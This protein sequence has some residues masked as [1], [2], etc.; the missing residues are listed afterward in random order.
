MIQLFTGFV[1]SGKSYNATRIATMVADA[2]LGNRWVIANFPIKKKKRF[3]SFLRRGEKKYIEPRWIYKPNEELT[4]KFLIEESL[5]RGWN[6]K[7]SSALIVFDEASIPFNARTFQRS[8]RLEWIKFLSQSRKFGYDVIF[9]TQDARM[10]DKQIRALCEYEVVHKKLNNYVYF[11]WLSLFGI[12][13]FA[14]VSYWNGLNARYTRGQLS[15]FIYRKKIA[16]RYDSLRLFDVDVS[17]KDND[18]T[19]EQEKG[20]RASATQGGF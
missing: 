8:D 6:K 7:E 16:E 9:I 1:G 14:A 3:L 13:L 2:P 10:L 4:V 20:P 11:K 12:T 17:A 18:A 19:A 15:L 5:R